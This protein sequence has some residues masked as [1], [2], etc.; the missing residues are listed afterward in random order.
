MG[1]ELE[2]KRG[3]PIFILNVEVVLTLEYNTTLNTAGHENP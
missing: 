2:T 3:D 1:T